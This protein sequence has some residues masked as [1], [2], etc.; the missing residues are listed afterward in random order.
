LKLLLYGQ[1]FTELWFSFDFQ[2]GSAREAAA[3]IAQELGHGVI[4]F[5]LCGADLLQTKGTYD[6]AHI[7]VMERD[8]FPLTSQMR[9][10]RLT[11]PV[12]TVVASG[13]RDFT[14]ASSTAVRAYITKGS[15]V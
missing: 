14:G 10:A 12:E 11:L 3:R 6:K 9:K 8:E 15:R 2:T 4:G 13:S 5:V 1:S 7:V